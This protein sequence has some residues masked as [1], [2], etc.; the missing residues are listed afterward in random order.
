LT[1]DGWKAT[2][3]QIEEATQKLRE[4]NAEQTRAAAERQAEEIRKMKSQAR[5]SGFFFDEEGN[6]GAS[7]RVIKNSNGAI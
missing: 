3:E 7:E 4:Y 1:A 6:L 5:S 2:K